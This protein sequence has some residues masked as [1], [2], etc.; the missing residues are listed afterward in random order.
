MVVLVFTLIIVQGVQA[1]GYNLVDQWGTPGTGNGEFNAPSGIAV[2]KTG[3]YIY[4]NDEGNDRIQKFSSDRTYVTQWSVSVGS[5]AIAVD[6][7]GSYV[8]VY[9]DFNGRIVRYQNDGTPEIMGT[10]TVPFT[11]NGIAVSPTNNVV[12]LSDSTNNQIHMYDSDSGGIELDHWGSTGTGNSEFNNP[13]GIAID[14]DGNVYVADSGNSRIQIFDQDGNYLDQYTADEPWGVDVDTSGRIYVTVHYISSSIFHL[15]TGLNDPDWGPGHLLQQTSGFSTAERIGVDST[16]YVYIADSGYNRIVKYEYPTTGNFDVSSYPLGAQ[17]WVDGSDSGSVTHSTIYGL[18]PGT[19]PVIL[20]YPGYYDYTFTAG[21]MEGW[22]IYYPI[23]QMRKIEP[24]ADFSAAPVSGSATLPVT[25]TD[26]STETPTG[27]AWY[28]G[29]EDYSAGWTRMDT[30]TPGWAPRYDHTAVAWYD[31]SIFLTSGYT[32]SSR[33][34][35]WW[36]L[37][38]GATWIQDIPGEAGGWT[39]RY[40]HSSVAMPDGSIMVMG[41]LTS[42]GNMNDVWRSTDGGHVWG[43]PTSSAA[44][45]PRSGHTSIA[46]PDGDIV[47]MGGWDGTFKNDVWLSTDKGATWTP[48]TLNAEWSPRSDHSSVVMPDGSIVLMGGSG[49]N[50]EVWRSVDK[51]AS[52]TRVDTISPKWSPRYGH[53]SVALPD[54]SIM[55]MGGDD[56]ERKNDVWRST[57]YGATWTE[58]SASAPWAPRSHASSVVMPDGSIVLMGGYNDVGSYY[59]DVWRLPTAGSSEQSPVHTYTAPGTYPVALQAFNAGGSGS[60]RKSGFANVINPALPVPAQDA[61]KAVIGVEGDITGKTISASPSEVG[62]NPTITLW[63]DKPPLVFTTSPNACSLVA[64]DYA[65][66]ANWEHPISYYCVDASGNWEKED[67]TT[68][69][70]NYAFTYATGAVPSP[71]D[72]WQPD[73]PYVWSHTC[74]ND[75]T[76]NYAVLISGGNDANHNYRRYWNDIAFMYINLKEYGYDPTHIT[77]MMSDGTSTAVDRCIAGYPTCTATDDSPR[78]L[79]GI[80]PDEAVLDAGKTTIL[81]TLDSMKPGGSRALPTGANLIVL[82]TAHGGIDANGHQYIYAWGGTGTGQY[83]TDTEL[84]GKLNQLTQINSITLVMENCNSG[85]FREEFIAGLPNQKRKILYAAAGNEPSWGNGFSNALT[86]A[87]AGHTRWYTSSCTPSTCAEN[88]DKGADTSNPEDERVSAVEAMVYAKARD[89]F[90]T[91]TAGPVPGKEHSD[92]QMNTLAAADATSQYVSTCAGTATQS[93]TVRNP[94]SGE[95]WA[96]ET[97]RL[98]NWEAKGL[99]GRNVKI[100]LYKSGA[101]N[102]AIVASPGVSASDPMSYPWTIPADQATSSTNIYTIKVETV[103]T[104]TVTGTSGAFKI[105]LKPTTNYGKL[106]IVTRNEAGTYLAVPF[107]VSRV[108]DGTVVATGTTTATSSGLTTPNIAPLGNYRVYLNL[109]GYYPISAI[110]YV[111][112]GTVTKT[113][114]LIAIPSDP[115]D[116]PPYGGV[117]VTSSPDGATVWVKESGDTVWMNTDVET[118]SGPFYLPPAIYE[119]KVTKFGYQDPLPQTV[120][121]ESMTPERGPVKVDFTLTPET[122]RYTFDGF[123]DPIEM[124]GVVNYAKAGQTV[125]VKWYLSDMNGAVANPDSFVS[126]RSYRISCDDL[127]GE[128]EA[129]IEE[130]STGSSGLQYLGDGNWQYNWKTTKSSAGKCYEMYIE[131][132]EE[133]TSMAARFR[134]T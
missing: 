42:T 32:G 9:D 126:L 106:K 80:T 103:D 120:T 109:A 40:G 62:P 68:P 22:T 64:V 131:F 130:Y 99:A 36:S 66:E 57:D 116:L 93:I 47:L 18:T 92:M 19:H 84:V 21:V 129:A 69:A 122:W 38:N 34:D 87:Y 1:D 96:R 86:T 28:F 76:S 78:N 113:Y 107:T 51:G 33:R 127:T 112:A 6:P 123:Y 91:A 49:N 70:T 59:N 115:N 5:G 7:Y 102:R 48:Q 82:T 31:G 89:P 30:V 83:I 2:D 20:K 53:T 108:T 104:P 101:F 3:G 75:C 46:L 72:D 41:G 77:V 60:I 44:W 98:I 71:G 56:G 35:V 15:D 125:P 105:S 55:L 117:D 132:D 61:V 94:A 17:I 74:V 24:D 63:A 90:Y 58:V 81:N 67:A 119:I 65:P 16:G 73:D 12:Y 43:S 85:G 124:E 79:D 25:F 118:N 39:P 4:V 88:Y 37:D 121:V 26:L 97:V 100:T 52:W 134:F 110:A 29:D 95:N 50:N 23:Y 114:T 27:W 10:Y 14:S 11:V 128:G 54:G 45:T 8:F 133:Q 13:M 111:S